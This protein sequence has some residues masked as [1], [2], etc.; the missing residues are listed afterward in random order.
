MLEDACKEG[1]PPELL[2]DLVNELQQEA[3]RP[4]AEAAG[5]SG[6]EA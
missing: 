5:N 3:D 2:L 6:R 4:A 1:Q